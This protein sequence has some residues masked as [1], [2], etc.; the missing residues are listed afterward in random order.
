MRSLLAQPLVQIALWL[1]VYALVGWKFGPFGL[2]I[3]APGL[4]AATVMPIWRIVAG[5]REGMRE[6][7]WMPVHGEHFVYKSTTIRVLEDES[8]FRWV[9]LADVR[10]V[11]DFN[12]SEGALAAAH[13]ARYQRMGK[14][15]QAFLRDDALCAHLAKST[16]EATQR[17]RTWVD[18]TV[19][20]PGGKVRERAGVV[21]QVD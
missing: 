9:C 3:A 18:R 5:L 1:G 6:R 4:A 10:K 20:L 7:V 16:E 2:V 17:F 8:H 21:P 19:A 15:A 12:A 13:G 11:I 14:P